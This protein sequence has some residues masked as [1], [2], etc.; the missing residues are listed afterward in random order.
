VEIRIEGNCDPI[1]HHLQHVLKEVGN[2][3]L[4]FGMGHSNYNSGPRI[5]LNVRRFRWNLCLDV[6]I[7]LDAASIRECEQDD[8]ND[9]DHIH[10]RN[11]NSKN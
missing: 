10:T 8:Q 1:S 3:Y 11:E 2:A 5:H 6:G 4:P 7:C 9:S